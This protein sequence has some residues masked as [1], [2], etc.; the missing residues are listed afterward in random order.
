MTEKIA[1][2]GAGNAGCISA[3]N[4]HY[5]RET[6]DY[7]GYEID[8][9]YDPT[10]PIER[11]GQGTQLNV[12]ESAFD[13]LDLDWIQKNHIKATPKH[14][15][16]Y[17]GWGKDNHDFFHLYRNGS[18]AMHYVPK[19][20]SECVLKSSLFNVV[21]KEIIEPEEEIDATYIVD[22]RDKPNN[23]D[24]SYQTLINPIN[25]AIFARKEGADSSLLWTENITTPNG[26]AFVIPNH[27]SISYGYLYNNTITTKE[28]AEKDFIERFDVEPN[29]NISFDNY[30]AKD[31]WRGE[32]TILNGNSYSFIEPME[33]VTSAVYHNVPECLYGVLIG[34]ESREEMNESIYK[35]LIQVQDFILWHYKNGSI[36][37]TPFWN[38]AQSLEYSNHNAL[39]DHIKECME[40]PNIINSDT[41]DDDFEYG[42]WLPYSFK[43][44]YNNVGGA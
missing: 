8:I 37:D 15:I 16:R 6:E 10:A 41:L 24:D 17:S 22:C 19:L 43:N 2:I 18:I 28:D 33:A 42:H 11:V 3:L 1:I 40:L 13:V 25:S 32:R 14:G 27:D 5:L 38:H 9:Y 21:E 30:V 29:D 7:K 36:Y 26:W 20:L 4:L 31:I 44:W 23:L 34:E 39:I 12:L 35:E